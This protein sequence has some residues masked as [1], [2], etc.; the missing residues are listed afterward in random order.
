MILRRFIRVAQSVV[1]RSGLLQTETCL[2]ST[3]SKKPGVSAKDV[4]HDSENNEFYIQLN[5]GGIEG[6]AYLQYSF[7]KPDYVDLQ[8][9]VVPAEFQNRGI[10]K[11]LA[12]TVFDH[13]VSKGMSI[14]PTCSYLQKFYNDNP[15]PEY[16]AKVRL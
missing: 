13:F 7:I 11:V 3:M 8:H 14:R 9:T 16:Q 2:C 15:L 5:E 1:P 12:Q 4:V 10:A 6:K